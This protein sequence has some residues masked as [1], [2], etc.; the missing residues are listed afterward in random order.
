MKRRYTTGMFAATLGTAMLG[1]LPANVFADETPTVC[2]RAHF[3]PW[4]CYWLEGKITEGMCGDALQPDIPRIQAAAEQGNHA[5][6]YR[7]GQLYASATWGVPRDYALAHQWLTQSARGGNRD[8][9]I[10]LARL[11]EFGRGVER[12]LEQALY[13]YEQAANKGPYK[14][15]QQKIDYLRN[16]LQGSD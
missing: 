13:W 8:G 15:L 7:L 5:A 11:Y 6:A 1:Q 14:G 3:E 9:Q 10:E 2:T 4:A 16:K 12:D